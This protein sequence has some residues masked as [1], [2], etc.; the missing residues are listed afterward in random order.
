MVSRV[1]ALTGRQL[2]SNVAKWPY[3]HAAVSPRAYLDAIR[4]SGGDPVLLDPAPIT[5]SDAA[6]LLGRFDALV[7]SGGPDV[8][9]DGYGERP[10]DQTYGVDREADDFESVLLRAAIAR[11]VP[12]LAICRGVQIVN[13]AMGGSLFQHIAEDPGVEPHGRPGEAN[14]ER[15]HDVELEPGSMLRKVMGADR[16]RCSCH[17]HQAVARVGDGLRV[18]AHAE[19]GIV[20]GLELDGAPLL[21]VQWHPEDTSAGDPVQ[22]RLFD[23]VCR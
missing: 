15:V 9:P 17:H 21:A 22:Q 16:A 10:H 5:A 11:A 6:G 23:W 19:D 1:V 13:V 12:T 4:R 2:G 14:G 20:E 8:D 18:N 3:A 7:L